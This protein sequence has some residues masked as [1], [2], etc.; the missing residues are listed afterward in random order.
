MACRKPTIAS[1]LPGNKLVVKDSVNG[2]HFKMGNSKDLAKK[3]TDLLKNTEKRK[4]F[5]Q[6]GYKFAQDQFS[7]NAVGRKYNKLFREVL[8]SK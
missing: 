7:I 5:A 8:L 2:F 4:A 1:D 3:I 6:K